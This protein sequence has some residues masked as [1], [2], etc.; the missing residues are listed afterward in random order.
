[1]AKKKKRWEGIVYSTDPDFDGG[2]E[3]EDV[4]ETLPPNKQTLRIY[5]DRLKGNKLLTRIDD[6]QGTDDDLKDLGKQLKQLC[7]CG[8]STK[9]GQILLQGSFRD[10]VA[11]KLRQM[12]YKVKLAGG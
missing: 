1:M 2:Y 9:N 6:F 3:E 8:G 4:I 5:L 11:D 7:G 12:G 10:K